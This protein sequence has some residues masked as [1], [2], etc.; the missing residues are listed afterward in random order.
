[1]T[2]PVLSLTEKGLIFA[3]FSEYDTTKIY[4]KGI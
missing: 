4:I 1:M 2:L 3:F